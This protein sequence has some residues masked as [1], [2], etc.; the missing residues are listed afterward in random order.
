M[1]DRL[2][3]L[4]RN[5]LA[6]SLTLCLGELQVVLKLLK[7]LELAQLLPV[8]RL[9][10]RR[11]RRHARLHVSARLALTGLPIVSALL[12]HVTMMP[13]RTPLA[14]PGPA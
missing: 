2:L 12:H 8:E 9:L 14:V 4:L 6:A 5:Q 11:L 13:A 7:L 3:W 1:R 10:R